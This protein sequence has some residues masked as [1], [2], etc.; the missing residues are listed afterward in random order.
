MS[1]I[2]LELFFMLLI[3]SEAHYAKLDLAIYF[4]IPKLLFCLVAY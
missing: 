3:Y 2:F 4:I 1:D